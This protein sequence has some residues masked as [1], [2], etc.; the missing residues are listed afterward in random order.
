MEACDARL[1]V[2]V[3]TDSNGL[4]V[5]FS[6]AQVRRV[7]VDPG[8]PAVIEVRPYTTQDWE[9]DN[10]GRVYERAAEMDAALDEYCALP[11]ADSPRCPHARSEM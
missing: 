5:A 4:H 7:G 8:R 10:E 2:T 6:A 1:S 11:D 3:V 9:R